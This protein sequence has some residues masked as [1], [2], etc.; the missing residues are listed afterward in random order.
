MRIPDD[1]SDD[2]L[3]LSRGGD[4]DW[5]KRHN[6]PLPPGS[7]EALRYVIDF[8][9]FFN[10]LTDHSVRKRIITGDTFLL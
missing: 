1:C 9:L 6:M 7:P 4:F 3:K 5:L 8:L 10:R 2:L